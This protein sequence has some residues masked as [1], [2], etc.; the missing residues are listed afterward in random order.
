[1]DSSVLSIII[2]LIA[3]LSFG[4]EK[5]P[6]PITAMPVSYTHL[7]HILAEQ[8]PNSGNIRAASAKKSRR[9][10]GPHTGL[11]GKILGVRCV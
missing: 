7:H 8:F 11:I 10:E 2:I 6:L 3:I 4:L 5:I 1:M 9:L